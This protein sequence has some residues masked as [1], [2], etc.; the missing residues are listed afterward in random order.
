MPARYDPKT[1]QWVY[2]DPLASDTSFTAP[3]IGASDTEIRQFALNQERL[4]SNQQSAAVAD[5]GADLRPAVASS[6][7]QLLR[8][9]AVAAGNAG[10]GLGTDY[11]DLAAGIADVAVQTGNLITGK[12]WNW[13]E[14]LND[15]DNPWTKWRRDTFKMETQAGQIVSNVARIGVALLSLPKFAI[16]GITAPLKV[17]SKVPVAGRVA[18]AGLKGIDRAG[19]FYKGLG[20]VDDTEDAITALQ[21]LRKALPN[22]SPAAKAVD[23]ATRNDW[24]TLTYREVAE[25]MVNKPQLS[26]VETWWKSTEAA[27]TQLSRGTKARRLKTVGEALAWDAFVA[28]NVFGE[29]DSE[30][31]ETFSDMLVMMDAPWAQA[32]GSPLATYAEDNAL[33]R[34]FKQMVEGM[35]M[36]VPLNAAL[37]TFRVYQFA[38]NFQKAS[39]ETQADILFRMGSEA[40]GIGDTLGKMLAN[41][42]VA[43]GQRVYAT[44]ALNTALESARKAEAAKVQFLEARA[45]ANAM[46]PPDGFGPGTGGA[47]APIQPPPSS[48]PFTDGADPV[49]QRLAQMEGVASPV[50]PDDVLYQQRLQQQA[51]LNDPGVPFPPQGQLPP[52]PGIAGQLPQA[53]T[54]G[55]L[56][57]SPIQTGYP[58]A[59]PA[60]A[61]GAGGPPVP[62]TP[63]MVPVQ[64]TDLGP[65]IPRG[66]S[67]VVTPQTI[68]DAFMRDSMRIFREARDMTLQEGP[69]GVFRSLSTEV[70]QLVP[71]TRVD[72]I[73][74]LKAF[75]PTANEVGMVNGVD[76]IWLNF[77]YDRG[78]QEGWATID[79]DTF[80]IKFNRAAA[81]QVDRDGA[82]M[83]Q[84][85]ALD[86]AAAVTDYN[87][88]L[89]DVAESF[90]AAQQEQPLEVDQLQTQRL[91]DAEQ[92]PAV[93]NATREAI[94][95][96]NEVDRFDAAEELRLSQAEELAIT[97][98]MS[99]E[100]V[101]REMLGRTLDELP[102]P[103]V[104]K[105]ETGRAWEVYDA[106][107]EFLVR[108]TTRRQAEAAAQRQLAEDRTA[109]IGRA[110]QLEADGTDELINGRI[111]EPM[112]ESDIVG[113]V[114]LTDQQ[115]QA[116]QQ[117][118]SAIQKQMRA[119]WEKR[120]GGQAFY[121]V[122][123]LGKGKKTFELTQG[124]MFDL[125]DGIKALLQ[126][127]EITGPRAKVLR[128]V[129]DKLSTQM[130]LMEPQA[131][132]QKFV[133]GIVDD[134]QQYLQ[135]GQFCDYL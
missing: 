18:Q 89:V 26:G 92:D 126:T 1:R 129:A 36:A 132:A 106:N 55:A 40:Q 27:V 125:A 11:L 99:D 103:E 37:D 85:E 87:Q 70:K 76:S 65:P 71:R 109:L 9:T 97:G 110:R 75:P 46:P 93:A 44:S 30:F 113:S 16:T 105:A 35:A 117:Y 39:P 72:A 64:V 121:N 10:L 20:K 119:D 4:A 111:G 59:D 41:E 28:F 124:E 84:A 24:L 73:E 8:E 47:L 6:P 12:G 56:P 69:D 101:V 90:K 96:A 3:P 100:E 122:N 130:M 61:M 25:G 128:N 98:Q 86:D 60:G 115:I 77:V 17:A 53:N 88:N 32:L 34:K 62:V 57:A 15:A 67:P 74:Y 131:R 114:K 135:G 112:L 120:T 19:D 134:A 94:D 68:R 13:D 123:D 42:G 118:S 81:A 108:T 48:I 104:R 107:G 63:G 127:G 78:L 38:R 5:A 23:R 80:Q 22:A 33:T 52:A 45:A 49:Q 50:N 58:G 95:A 79:P 2:D 66:P 83:R 29:G 14:V 51:L 82:V 133:Q 91:A 43:T 21:G 102:T 7:G 54:A 31:D 116:V